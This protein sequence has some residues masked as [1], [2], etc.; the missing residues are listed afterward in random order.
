MAVTD[1]LMAMVR[2]GNE[3][4][5]NRESALRKVESGFISVE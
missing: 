2:G 4:M 5:M 3:E 1:G